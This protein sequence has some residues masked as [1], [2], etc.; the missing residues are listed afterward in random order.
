MQADG[1]YQQPQGVTPTAYNP[2]QY[3]QPQYQQPNVPVMPQAPVQEMQQTPI[4]ENNPS[5]QAATPNLV[6]DELAKLKKLLDDGV[7]TQ[8][9]FDA[10]KT[11]LLNQ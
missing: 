7:I 11:K 2:V 9:E 1:Y 6:A 8:E 4:Q 3:Q 10:Q 5:I